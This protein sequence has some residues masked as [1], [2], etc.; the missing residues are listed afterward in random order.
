VTRNSE[1]RSGYD[2]ARHPIDTGAAQA[3]RVDD[4]L[5]GGKD[6]YEA[7]REVGLELL[8]RDPTL[9]GMLRA[10]RA[11]LTRVVTFLVRDAGLRQFLVIGP[12]IPTPSSVHT[13]AQAVAPESRVVYVEDDPVVLA[14]ARAFMRSARHGKT[15]FIRADLRDPDEILK[16]P[17][18]T[19]TLDARRPIGL[20]IMDVI[21][22]LRDVDRP[23]DAVRR[24]VRWLPSGSHLAMNTP[25]ADIDPALMG[26]LAAI[27]ERGGI[28]VVPR[29][30]SEFERFFVG[31]E[32]VPPGVVPTLAWRPDTKPED[33]D[34]V[35]AYVAVARTP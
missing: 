25:A 21:H 34:A 11:L 20:V 14:H 13:L 7:D 22:H 9:P 23:H 32:L 12:G 17:S 30:R 19:A 4:F 28:T 18:L 15:A 33:A 24:L 10:Q 5:L 2:P 31:L 29:T 6:N 26:S 3:A 8:R 27:A 16:H 35:Q 1:V